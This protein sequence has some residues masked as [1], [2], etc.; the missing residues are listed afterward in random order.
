[1]RR[2]KGIL[3]ALLAWREG[4]LKKVFCQNWEKI[5]EKKHFAIYNRIFFKGMYV[6][7]KFGNL[8]RKQMIQ[9]FLQE[10]IYSIS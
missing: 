7:L 8:F 10:E 2:E 5:R 1:M 3:C 4:S 6:F 9:H